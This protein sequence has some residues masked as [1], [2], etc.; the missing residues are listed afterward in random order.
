MPK[1]N[2]RERK[3]RIIRIRKEIRRYPSGCSE[4]TS[5]F[6]GEYHERDDTFEFDYPPP[7][8]DDGLQIEDQ[9]QE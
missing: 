8:D 1:H 9:R 5:W 3:V 6:R 2:H 4:L 7:R